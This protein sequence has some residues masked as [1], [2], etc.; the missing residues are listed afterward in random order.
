MI[1]L[2]YRMNVSGRRGSFAN[3]A[4]DFDWTTGACC[5]CSTG[6]G[7]SKGGR[8]SVRSGLSDERGG[9]LLRYAQNQ[10]RAEARRLKLVHDEFTEMVG[11]SGQY[12]MLDIA[13]VVEDIKKAA[14]L[15]ECNG[16]E[17]DLANK[18][19]ADV[20]FLGVVKKASAT[21][22]SMSVV[23]V[24]VEK[25]TPIKNASAVVHGNTDDAWL[26]VARWLLRN[27]VLPAKED[28]R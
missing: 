14:P 6:R 28:A 16:C 21:L 11:A 5:E 22:L 9:L 7:R 17:M 20:L 26:G 23:V 27:R 10:S 25:G 24:D 8:F 1:S 18:I 15:N 12:E 13:P 3:G 2:N 4:E 19:G